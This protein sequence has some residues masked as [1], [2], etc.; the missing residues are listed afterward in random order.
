[1]AEVC[2]RGGDELHIGV[3]SDDT[4][5]RRFYERH[6]FADTDPDTGSGMRLYLQR[7]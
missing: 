6:G 1:M 2:S 4:G 5:A 7:M 3:D